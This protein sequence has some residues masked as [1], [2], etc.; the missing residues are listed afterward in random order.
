MY[1]RQHTV[2]TAKRKFPEKLPFANNGIFSLRIG[3]SYQIENS[4][5]NKSFI[6]RPPYFVEI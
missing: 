3:I 1:R 6:F 5:T 4:A 2:S